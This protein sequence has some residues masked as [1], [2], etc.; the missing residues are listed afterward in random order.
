MLHIP[1]LLHKR[2]IEKN[3]NIISA[4]KVRTTNMTQPMQP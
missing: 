3:E 4:I 1:L 2:S